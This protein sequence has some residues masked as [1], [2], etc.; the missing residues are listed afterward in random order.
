MLTTYRIVHQQLVH[1]THACVLS[2]QGFMCLRLPAILL[3]AA[4]VVSLCILCCVDL[5]SCILGHVLLVQS[6]HR[7][8]RSALDMY[9]VWLTFPAD[10]CCAA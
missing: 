5:A 6:L 4:L 8:Q 9:L 3:W 1:K 10:R 7:Q 2:V